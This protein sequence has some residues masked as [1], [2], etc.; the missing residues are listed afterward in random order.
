MSLRRCRWRVTTVPFAPVCDILLCFCWHSVSLS[1]SLIYRHVVSEEKQPISK[2]QRNMKMISICKKKKKKKV[3]CYLTKL[4]DNN[5]LILKVWQSLNN[6]FYAHWKSIIG[7]GPRHFP[8]CFYATTCFLLWLTAVM[9]GLLF[10]S[11]CIRLS[12]EMY[13]VKCIIIN[14]IFGI[15]FNLLPEGVFIVKLT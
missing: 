10:K 2:Q 15:Y 13:V 6:G 7:K 11:S 12:D 3:L 4:L 9:W 5:S 1:S 14:R 8:V